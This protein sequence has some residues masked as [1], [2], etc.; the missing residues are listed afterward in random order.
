MSKET[1]VNALT[2]TINAKVAEYR[3][4]YSDG[5]RAELEALNQQVVEMQRTRAAMI[6]EGCSPCPSCSSAPLGLI[7]KLVVD[8]EPVDGFS[9]GCEL[10]LDHCATGVSLED[11]R[12]AWEAGPRVP[13]QVDD[14]GAVVKRASGGWRVPRDGRQLIQTNG[15]I[16]SI[17]ADGRKINWAKPM[18]PD[19][20]RKLAKA[21]VAGSPTVPVVS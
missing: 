10:C 16:V 7:Q 18:A 17:L 12:K 6:A 2:D 4:K 1:D 20:R 3:S 9:I 11:A 19:Q 21:A 15:E 5:S 8:R 14:N 13:E